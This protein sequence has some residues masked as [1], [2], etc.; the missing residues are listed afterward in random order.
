VAAV[1]AR[2]VSGPD[3]VYLALLIA[4]GACAILV[5]DRAWMMLAVLAVVSLAAAALGDRTDVQ[6]TSRSFFGVLRESRTEDASLG[7]EV[8]MLAHG[9]TLHGAQAQAEEFKC[10][11]TV[12]Y[13]PGGPIGRTFLTEQARKPSMRIGAVGLGTG[14]V[15]AY[16]RPTDRLTFFEIDPLVVEIS[17]GDGSFTFVRDC[18]KGR[19]DFVIGDARLTLGEQPGRAF[20]LLLIDAFSSDSIPTHLMTVEA[21]EGYLAKLKPDGVL[22]LHLSNRNLELRDVAQAVALEAGGAALIQRHHPP[23]GITTLWES[24]EDVM[25]VG[26]SAQALA[27]YVADPAWHA[28]RRTGT[29]PWTDD[30]TNV[31]GALVEQM[32]DRWAATSQ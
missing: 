24:D 13:A 16:V 30:Y 28:A 11:P 15:A 5:R 9:T 31:F 21:I 20:D 10:R 19:V 8:R 32:K 12:Y 26:H 3:F 23:E 22:I 25:I 7:G 14:A 2:D 27:P 1:V 17:G 18:A 29:R 4:G 6:Q